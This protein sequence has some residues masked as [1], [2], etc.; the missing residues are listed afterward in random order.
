L[1]DTFEVEVMEL[2]PKATFINGN[3]GVAD[4]S[5]G[6]G[7]YEFSEDANGNSGK[8]EIE[9]TPEGIIYRKTMYTANPGRFNQD[10]EVELTKR[11]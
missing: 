1:G 8:V 11:K 7:S 3:E 5:S 4:L 2:T 6:K 10:E 9:L